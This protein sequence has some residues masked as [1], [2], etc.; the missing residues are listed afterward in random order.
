MLR[1][2]LIT[3]GPWMI[4]TDAREELLELRHN[5]TLKAYLGRVWAKRNEARPRG[6]VHSAIAFP[7]SCRTDKG[8]VL[9]DADTNVM[10][11]RK[12]G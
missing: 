4:P 12:T 2:W 1:P 5:R 8:F 10:P 11:I 7:E 6:K 3:F 9:R